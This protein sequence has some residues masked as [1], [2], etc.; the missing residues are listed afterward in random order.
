MVL[1]GIFAFKTIQN[2]ETD[3][4][5][6][7]YQNTSY[8]ESQL[9]RFD[10]H[11]FRNSA[12]SLCYLRL[13]IQNVFAPI[14][15]HDSKLRPRHSTHKDNPNRPLTPLILNKIQSHK[16]KYL[17][18]TRESLGDFRTKKCNNHKPT[19]T[20]ERRT[21][22]SSK[23]ETVKRDSKISKSGIL[24]KFGRLCPA[25]DSNCGG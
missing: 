15:L 17:Y 24:R 7:S 5:I 20:S 23:T 13:C 25:R 2:G 19:I 8:L 11:I 18:C 16:N 10:L 9:P 12:L 21:S 14:C 6:Q 4:K 1:I 22:T 3:F